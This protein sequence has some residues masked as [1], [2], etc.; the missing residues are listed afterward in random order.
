MSGFL[1]LLMPG[2][3]SREDLLRKR[4]AG[5][6]TIAGQ[7]HA[8]RVRQNA[9]AANATAATARDR[10][11][12]TAL[13]ARTGAM[14]QAE[15]DAAAGRDFARQQTA[16]MKAAEDELAAREE[17]RR[18]FKRALLGK[19]ITAGGGL[20]QTLL[21]GGGG[22]GGP[23]VAVASSSPG[24]PVRRVGIDAAD[25]RGPLGGLGGLLRTAAPIAGMAVGGPVGG[26][27]GGA[28][29]NAL[30]GGPA[31]QQPTPAVSASAPAGQL[32]M[33][34]GA[35]DATREE[36]LRRLLGGF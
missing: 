11:L 1:S 33:Q 23:G 7:A 34:T 15:L 18:N 28:L 36:F 14:Q 30:G 4:A 9:T 19:L 21:Q 16:E 22:G 12:S 27:V 24:G 2:L 5:T 6:G 3:R 13:A 32:Q 31:A 10:G 25:G 35:S 17:Q 8:Q 20:A 29:G 26:M